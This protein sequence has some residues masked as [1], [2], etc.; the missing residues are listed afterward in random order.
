[1]RRGVCLLS[2]VLF[3]LFT[4]VAAAQ[5]GDLVYRVP[6]H[7]NTVVVLNV[8]KILASPLAKRENWRGMQE[9]AFSA[10]LTILPPQAN[11]FLMAAEMD[12]EFMQA[13]WEMAM[14]QTSYDTSLPQIAA[15][16]GGT[17]DR[18]DRRGAVRLP[19]D[20]YLVQFGKTL[21]GVMRPANRQSVAR[22][23]NS[24]DETTNRN[25]LSPYLTESVSFA[26]NEGTPIIM[27][28]DLQNAISPEM[29][30]SRLSEDEA[31]TSGNLD[32]DQLVESLSSI[33]GVTLGI[34][35]RDKLV[36]AIKVDFEKDV[37]F[38]G[39]RAKPM[40]LS[41]LERQ[42]AMIDEFEDWTATVSGKQVKIVGELYPS[43]MRRIM[44]VLDAPPSLQQ[45]MAQQSSDPQQNEEDLKKLA[46]QQYFQ[47]VTQQVSDLR[48]KDKQT[49]GQVGIWCGR[50]AR[51]IDGL[52]ILNVDEELLEYGSFVSAALRQCESILRGVGG[53]SRVRQTSNTG[54]GYNYD[55]NYNN[56]YRY[57]RWGAYGRY[58]VRGEVRAEQSERIAIRTQERVAGASSSREVMQQIDA[59]TGEIRR[60]MVAK[61]NVE[62]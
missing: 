22:W 60:K 2:I 12:Y 17:I 20:A 49:M 46:S 40:L 29:V 37:E 43:G 6:D 28:M 39:D 14:S 52:P 35:I 4:N 54:G 51:K 31:V 11:Y 38:L 59:A 41:A 62:F 26:E 53:R 19:D 23:L 36:G 50:A 3:S 47:S 58:G 55:N 44:S 15:K 16:Y 7:A 24:I 9:Q 13:S 61:Y 21:V 25:R 33:R 30:R 56:N 1:M 27:A 32:I 10:G 34:T 18:F 48:G 57:G 45:T 5:F 8:Q 42:S